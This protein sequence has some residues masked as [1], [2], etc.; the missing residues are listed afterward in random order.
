V[1]EKILSN[2]FFFKDLKERIKI[3]N[4]DDAYL[5]D[6]SIKEWFL[7]PILNEKI[8]INALEYQKKFLSCGYF[9]FII[10][11]GFIKEF[12]DIFEDIKG[13][14]LSYSHPTYY[15]MMVAKLNLKE[16]SDYVLIK[17]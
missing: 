2:N 15:G 14:I 5:L 12:Q 1:G 6:L 4:E 8:I 16:F 17:K 11:L 7:N 3:L 9:G 10:L 13:E